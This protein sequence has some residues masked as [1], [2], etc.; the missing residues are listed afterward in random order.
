MTEM[1]EDLC[2]LK[3]KETI[4][5][6]KLAV[7]NTKINTQARVHVQNREKIMEVDHKKIK[8]VLRSRKLTSF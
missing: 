2:N 1:A 8:K 5:M 4:T 3:L 7:K 6:N